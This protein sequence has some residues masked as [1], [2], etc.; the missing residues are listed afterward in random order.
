MPGPA[1]TRESDERVLE[2]LHLRRKGMSLGEIARRFGVS[3]PLVNEATQKVRK[4]DEWKSGE[5]ITDWH[6]WTSERRK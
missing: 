3:R 4:E 2:W 6:Y 1:A 5:V